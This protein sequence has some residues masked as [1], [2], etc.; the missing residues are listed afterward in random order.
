M[1]FVAQRMPSIAG[2]IAGFALWLS[3]GSLATAGGDTA[4]RF[5]FLP[6]LWLLPVLVLGAAIL[7][8]VFRLSSSTALPL[9]FSLVLL[10]PW[11][12]GRVPAAFL[13]WSGPIVV[14][15]WVGVA[16]AMFLSQPRTAPRAIEFRPLLPAA[17]ALVAYLAGGWS[18]ADRM[19]SGD[20]PHYLIIAQ[21]ILYDRDIQVE[22]NYAEAQHRDYWSGP[23]RP[24]YIQRGTN[25]E[26]YSIHAP[27]L[28]AVVAPAFALAGH[29]AVVVF[30][31]LVAA[32]GSGLLWRAAHALTG[33]A[34]A[35]WFAWAAGALSAPF[36]FEAFA[37]YPDGLAATLV[38]FAALPL[39]ER[40]VS[41]FRWIAVGAALGLL[42]WLHTRFSIISAMLG[43]VLFFRLV[44]SARGRRQ[45]AP[46]LLVP[47]G[48]ALAWFG[49]FRVIYG[50]F[51]PSSPYGGST[52]TSAGNILNGL[53]ALWLDQQFG[54]LPN[55]PV[56][57]FCLAGL[58]VLARQ[59]PRL[60]IELISVGV[61]Y[62]LAV[63]AF[64][65]WWAGDSAPARFLAPLLPLFAIPAAS[66][67]SSASLRS[68][69]A[70]G[71]AALTVSLLLTATLAG[72]EGGVLAFN[73]RDGYSRAAEWVSPLIDFPLGLPSFFRQAPG[74]AVLRASVWVGFLCAAVWALWAFE[75]K[76]NPRGGLALAVP[77]SLAVAIMGAATTVWAL[78]GGAINKEIALSVLAGYDGRL[79]PTGFD[80]EARTIVPSQTLLPK[81][82]VS[83]PVR[84]GTPSAQTLLLAPTPVPGGEYE[85]HLED[86]APAHG[87][88]KLVIGRLA[89][90]VKIW[91]L[92]GDLRHAAAKVQLPVTVGSLVVLGDEGASSGTLTLIPR[93]IWEAPSRLTS[94]IARRVEPY[95]PAQVFFFAGY[96][97]NTFLEGPGF[98]VRGGGGV[99][100]AVTRDDRRV[101]LQMFVR[102]AAATNQVQIEINGAE[103][104]YNLE[105]GEELT[106][107]VPVAD[108]RPG[109]LIRIQSSSG[110]RPAEVEP[111]STDTRFLGVWI[112]FR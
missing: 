72:A 69:R 103:R 18:L 14:G 35:A 59:R 74:G 31:A 48:S 38:L 24:H 66:L 1:T 67:W 82:V 57:A 108:P 22:N 7:A 89:H 29:P 19:P 11:I 88:G 45:I 109:A 92:A 107:P 58:A 2:A 32:L 62:L 39:F 94:E 83:T 98:W 26:I 47:A 77:V 97:R 63:S 104:V 102:N 6:P 42:P 40:Q 4:A 23:L 25:G 86:D 37:V 13:I 85:L 71:L 21:S 61:P 43:L 51:D 101:P 68:T 41:T 73:S 46:F 16:V 111:G 12:P 105:P 87:S 34:S 60:S 75:R 64:E 52:R 80:L 3:M 10:L 99:Q 5:G 55:A 110:F 91:D 54:I 36:F 81:L 78:D 90:P 15:V 93:R 70:L 76:A 112:E 20:E 106:I 53:P 84:R 28:P 17:V 8:W 44:E 56:F 27:G 65:Q 50:S 49:F 33:N 95:G 79:R 30:L 96:D 9:F 100:L